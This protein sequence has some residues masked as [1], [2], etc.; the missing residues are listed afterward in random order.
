MIEGKVPV[1]KHEHIL[2]QLDL[3]YNVINT[4]KNLKEASKKTGYSIP[5]INNVIYGLAKQTDGYL[6]RFEPEYIIEKERHDNIISTLKELS[7]I[8]NDFFDVMIKHNIDIKL[9][10]ALYKKLKGKKL[11][12]KAIEI[13]TKKDDA[14]VL[15]DKIFELI[16]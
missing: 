13:L 9:S 7:F 15:I 10:Y 6:F 11:L 16:K 12:Y 8:E 1:D 5:R 4:F 3:E 14:N 2:Y